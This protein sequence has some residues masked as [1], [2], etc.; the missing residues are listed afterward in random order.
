MYMEKVK[1]VALLFFVYFG[2]S[3][4]FESNILGSVEISKV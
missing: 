2:Q 1:F 3:G 4:C